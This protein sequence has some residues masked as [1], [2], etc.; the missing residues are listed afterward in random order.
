[1]RS[2]MRSNIL[3][4]SALS[5]SYLLAGCDPG[6]SF[7]SAEP[8]KDPTTNPTTTPTASS[9]NPPSMPPP[10]MTPV[11]KAGEFQCQ[12]KSLMECDTK[13]DKWLLKDSCM[14]DRLCDSKAGVCLLCE[15][16]KAVSCTDGDN[17]KKE[18]CNPDG[19]STH[20]ESCSNSTPYCKGNGECVECV[21]AQDCA[22]PATCQTVKCEMNHC[23]VGNAMAGDACGTNQVCT[24]NGACGDC[25][26]GE[27][28]CLNNGVEQC[29]MKGSWQKQQDCGAEGMVCGGKECSPIA[30]VELSQYHSC[31]R[32]NN[33]AAFCWGTNGFDAVGDIGTNGNQIKPIELTDIGKVDQISVGV[34]NT[35]VRKEG[36]VYCWGLNDQGILGV[37][38]ET[39]P[40]SRKPIELQGLVDVAHVMVGAG[41]GCAISKAKKVK[42]WG[43][44]NEGILGLG[45][46]EMELP[47]SV[48]P[49][50]IP[51]LDNVVKI[52]TSGETICALTNQPSA[53]VYCWGK[54]EDGILGDGD[55][56]NHSVFSPLQIPQFKFENFDDIYLGKAG[57]YEIN[58]NNALCA[59]KV[60]P[61]GD[62]GGLTTARRVLCLGR[63]NVFGDESLHPNATEIVIGMK[64]AQLGMGSA[65]TCTYKIDLFDPNLI[66]PQLRCRGSN[67]YG[68]VGNDSYTTTNQ[69]QVISDKPVEILAVGNKHS[70]MVQGGKLF[71]WGKGENGEL[72]NDNLGKYSLTPTA[73]V[74]P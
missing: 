56:S 5:L 26:P 7:T 1:M 23:Q 8:N 44:N 60:I 6:P 19:A 2:H 46:P 34:F 10:T 61:P 16:G 47:Y 37:S 57:F 31:A 39:L 51:N 43:G 63:G 55:L 24:G 28:R 11:C 25:I 59:R 71:C 45:K 12:G 33:G 4:F 9:S 64:D 15:A 13:N 67:E 18:I 70:C 52:V 27:L 68:Q 62:A 65:H 14:N 74:W 20:P 49:V 40:T 22:Q 50:E 32:L 69:W 30:Q 38:P 58:L 53:S 3:V 29:D 36:K 41:F 17:T 72:G 21:L 54:G 48:I 66:V 42:C 73:V 35:C